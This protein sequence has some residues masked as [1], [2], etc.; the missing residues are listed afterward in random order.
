MLYILS[1]FRRHLRLKS[2]SSPSKI[3]SLNNILFAFKKSVFIKYVQLNHKS[4]FLRVSCFDVF[5]CGEKFFFV[6]F[7]DDALSTETP[8]ELSI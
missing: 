4:L 5:L 7:V 6:V 3:F 8:N 2:E 1:A